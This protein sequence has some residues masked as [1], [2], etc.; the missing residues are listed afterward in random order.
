MPLFLTSARYVNVSL[1]ET[2]LAAYAGMPAR[3][4]RVIEA[5]PRG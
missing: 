1:E 2:Y 3:W 5:V 4:K